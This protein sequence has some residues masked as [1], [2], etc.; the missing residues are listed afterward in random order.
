MKQEI[1]ELIY[2][3]CL[4]LYGV[5]AVV[6]LEYPEQEFGDLS[7]NVAMRLSKSL[8]KNPRDLAQEIVEKL[9]DSPHFT[10][11]GV[12]GPGFINMTLQDNLLMDLINEPSRKPL[13]GMKILVEYSDPN[14]FKPLH[15]GHLY[16]TLVGDSIAR[17]VEN[18]GAKTI[19]LNYGGD[20]GLHVAKSMWAILVELGGDNTESMNKIPSEKIAGWMGQKYVEGNNAYE[21]DEIAKSEIIEINKKVYELHSSNDHDTPFAQIYWILRDASYD[22]F[23]QLYQDLMVK[24]F[25]RFIPESEVTELGLETVKNQLEKGVFEESEGAVIFDGEKYGLHKRVF[26]NSAGLPTYETKDVGLSL[27]KWHDYKFDESII[28]TANEQAQYM[29]VV[30]KAIEQI[31]TEPALRTKHLT[32]GFV[33]LSGG[34][35]MSSREGNIVTAFDILHA[36]REAGEKSG[37]ASKENIVIGAVKYA[38]IKSRLGGD[39][40][41]DPEESIAIEGNSGPY[42]Q[43]AHTRAKSILG[44][45]KNENPKLQENIIYDAS[46]RTLLRKLSHYN[47]CIEKATLEFAPHVICTY[48]YEL[49]QVFN[50]FY[51]QSKVVDDPRESIRLG[52]VSVYADTLKSGLELLGIDAPDSM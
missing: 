37:L 47:D 23:K 52:L 42:L 32:H 18:A 14:P 31:E 8:S 9:H 16:T 34:I 48:L 5:E 51:E 26:I 35:K 29:Q 39:I 38:F 7:T 24:P 30:I 27:T 40:I 46:E 4:S 49:A 21:S 25:D 36:A 17:L 13:S 1:V 43:Y 11:V 6:E 33:K 19:R 3:T 44:K 50:R 10:Q 28:I 45:S 2:S 12:A 22:F 41:Y 15:A 20:V